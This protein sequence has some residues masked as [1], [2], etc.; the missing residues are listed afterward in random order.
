MDAQVLGLTAALDPYW[1]G[2][3]YGIVLDDGEVSVGDEAR[4]A[5]PPAD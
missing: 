4:L 5:S 3:A 2:G 1:N